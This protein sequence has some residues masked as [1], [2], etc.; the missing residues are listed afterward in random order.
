MPSI[1]KVIEKNCDWCGKPILMWMGR[2]DR[3][4]YHEGCRIKASNERAKLR[5]KAKR[6][7][8]KQQD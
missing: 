5:V 6:D 4:G 3:P 7:M 2:A 8:L 1:G